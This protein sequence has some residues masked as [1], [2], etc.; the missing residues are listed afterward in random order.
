M[1]HQM[2]V[3][4]CLAIPLPFLNPACTSG[5]SVHVLLKPSL[6]DFE[7]NLTSMWKEY[8]CP[9]VGTF[10]GIAFLWHWNENWPFPSCG[11]CWVSQICWHIE[12]STLTTLPFRI[13]NSSAGIPS[14]AL[15]MLVV[16]LPKA[17]LVL[18]SRMISLSLGE[19]SHHCG[20]L[21]PEDFFRTVLLCVLATPS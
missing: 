16:M 8:N 11:H 5:I 15:A 19:W 2:L 13:L 3:M 14:P 6:K 10:F 9:I 20:Y 1:I 21:G 12:C 7:Q 18:Y 4:Q 17:H